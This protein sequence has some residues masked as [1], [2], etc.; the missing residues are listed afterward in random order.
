LN[1]NPSP[2]L[3]ALKEI[4]GNKKEYNISDVVFKIA[5][6]I[7]SAGRMSSGKK[8]VDILISETVKDARYKVEEVNI[9]NDERRETDKIITKEAFEQIDA[10]EN[11]HKRKTTVLYDSSWHKGVIGI[12]ASRMIEKHY[13]PTIIFS[14]SDGVLSG[15]ARSVR[16]FDLYAALEKCSDVLIQFGGHKYAAG[17]TLKEENL[18]LFKDRFDEAVSELIKEEH[19]QPLIEIDA[20]LML[21][22]I[23]TSFYK[24]LRQFAPFGPGNMNPI[25]CSESIVIKEFRLLV[26][27][28]DNHHLKFKVFHPS[29]E[30]QVFDVIAFGMGNRIDELADGVLI[31]LLYNV[32]ENVWNGRSSLQLVAKDLRIH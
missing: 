25:F 20:S 10:D 9:F 28:N 1:K 12:V 27:R 3:E 8:A 24:I 5:P 18:D 19:L 16:K 26:D 15:S 29:D 17:M 22:D 7:N 32:D 13:R 31:D 6:R 21:S 23:N 14:G 11:F 2:G 4:V 30:N